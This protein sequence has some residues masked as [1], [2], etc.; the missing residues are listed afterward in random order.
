[1]Q[2]DQRET[3]I[4]MANQIA[5]NLQ[6]SNDAA[7]GVRNHL[8]KFWA[9]SMKERLI[10]CLDDADCDLNPIARQAV[11]QMAEQRRQTS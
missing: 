10:G 1:M 7:T 4:H 5:T 6:S 3:L 11:E 8:E 9:R 2:H